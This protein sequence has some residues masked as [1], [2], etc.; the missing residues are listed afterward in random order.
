MVSVENCKA[1]SKSKNELF[2]MFFSAIKSKWNN[3]TQVL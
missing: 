2:T 3:K 1:Q